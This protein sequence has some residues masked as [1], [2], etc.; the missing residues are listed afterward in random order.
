MLLLLLVVVVVTTGSSS[1]S[2][3][4]S[5]SSLDARADHDF[6]EIRTS[7]QKE[8]VIVRASITTRRL[9]LKAVQVELT[10]KRSEF[11]LVKVSLK[12]KQERDEC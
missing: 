4:T 9:A 7:L 6:D 5:R 12:E 10:L 3:S 1:S 2:S 11:A 8:F